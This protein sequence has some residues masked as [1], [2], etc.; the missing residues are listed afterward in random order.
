MDITYDPAKNDKN[1]A[2]RG[3]SFELAHG[4]EWNSALV[5]EDARQDYSEVRYQALGKI[6]ER[7]YMLVFTVRGEAIR[8]I[9]L[10]KANSREVARYEKAQ[11]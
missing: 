3:L 4:F 7:L 1:I 2:E 6:D 11:S 10:R 5:I 8:V 9:S